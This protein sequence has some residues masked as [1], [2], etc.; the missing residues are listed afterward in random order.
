VSR[1]QHASAVASVVA[2]GAATGCRALDV[3]LA[4][5][6]DSLEP[7]SCSVLGRAHDRA[8]GRL[9]EPAPGEEQTTTITITAEV[10]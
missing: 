6:I 5:G 10:R 4:G 2:D 7:A 1:E 8:E 3:R 9:P